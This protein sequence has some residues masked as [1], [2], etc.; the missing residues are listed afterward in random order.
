MQFFHFQDF[1]LPQEVIILV[2]TD[3]LT[4]REN[5]KPQVSISSVLLKWMKVC[6]CRSNYYTATNNQNA[7]SWHGKRYKSFIEEKQGTS[8]LE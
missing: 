5:Y 1:T 7:T 6:E 8:S 4:Q 2:L 3:A